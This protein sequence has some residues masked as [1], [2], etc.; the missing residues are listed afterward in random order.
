MILEEAP[1]V[2]ASSPSRPW[3]LLLLS[4]KTNTALETATKNLVTYLKQHSDLNLA[5][6]A[7]TLKVGRRAFNYRRMMVCQTLEESIKTLESLEPDQ[8]FTQFQEPSHHSVIFMFPGQG[9]Q[10]I[11]MG[12]ELYKT[13]KKFREIVDYC[14]ETLKAHLNLDLRDILYPKN[15]LS[16]DKINE[17][18]YTQPALFVVEYAL[19]KL[20]IDWGIHPEAMIGHSIGEYVAACLAGVFSLEDA[21]FLIAN[22]GKL[23]QQQPPGAMISVPLSIE[24]I[25]PFLSSEIAL[26]ANNAP[27]LSVLSGSIEAINNLQKQLENQGI[28]SKRL[29][30]SHAFHSP[31][32]DLAE[33]DFL[34]VVEEVSL[35]PPQ[36]P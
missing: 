24:D 6:L 1:T 17:T 32:M 29:Q 16:D 11:N 18:L 12:L 10:Y 3:Q 22:R 7:Y 34:K 8:V 36:I 27:Q 9:T 23:M 26:A 5:D 21:L 14:C 25:K 20:L 2:P 19:A 28:T 31:M 15:S 13:E 33:T 4:A 35:N 30:T